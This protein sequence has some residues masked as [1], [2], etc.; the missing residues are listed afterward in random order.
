MV[1]FWFGLVVGC[2]GLFFLLLL[3]CVVLFLKMS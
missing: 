1:V 3:C 2:G